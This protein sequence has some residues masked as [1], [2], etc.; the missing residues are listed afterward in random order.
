MEARPKEEE[1]SFA[2][3][4]P[5][6]YPP[7]P[8][9]KDSTKPSGNYA[10]ESDRLRDTDNWG[11]MP[12]RQKKYSET[13]VQPP[14]QPPTLDGTNDNQTKNLGS[15]TT[16]SGNRITDY[17]SLKDKIEDHLCCKICAKERS[18]SEL[19]GFYKFLEENKYAPTK[20]VPRRYKLT[21]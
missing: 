18:T 5:K 10:I 19:D 6:K 2:F 15:T 11:D 21:L 17:P 16:C 4:T 3:N 8:P 20:D 9:D 14:I 1:T 12:K 7:S 13:S